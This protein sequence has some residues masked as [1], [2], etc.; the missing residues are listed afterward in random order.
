MVKRDFYDILG[1]KK[2]ASEKEI[3]SAYRRL[4][5]KYHP[6]TN[7]GDKAAEQK[8][9]EVT[10]AYN[11]LIDNEKRKLYDQFG[12]AAFDGSMGDGGFSQSD[13]AN[14]TRTSDAFGNGGYREYHYT[15][16]NMDDIF[17]DIFGDMFSG[18][19]FHERFGRG[20]QDEDVYEHT[21][22]KNIYSDI[23]IDFEEAVFGC[24]K[25]LHFD[26]N[27]RNTLKVHIPAGIDEGQSVRLK[28]KGKPGRGGSE[29]GDL[30]LKVHI[31]EKAG[32]KRE[33]RDIYVTESIPYTTAVLGG[34][35]RF[36]TLYG[37]VDCRIPA[38]TQ[39]GS[40]IRIKNKGIVAMND[41]R[42]HGD[43][44]V[45][46]QIQVPKNVTGEERRIIEELKQAQNHGSSSDGNVA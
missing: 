1:V 25:I 40:K 39:P 32:Y 21:K 12:M 13:S 16:G 19:S 14:Y 8:F 45:I 41:S 9:K 30:L 29:A 42:V 44:Y 28:G 43:E 36:R 20:F 46:I 18:A 24:D 3:K 11:I 15:S 37:P 22:G 34:Q 31:L 27:S 10:E 35:A 2:N 6:D 7:P 33:G 38:G 4:A 26:G 23:T 5:K 17:G